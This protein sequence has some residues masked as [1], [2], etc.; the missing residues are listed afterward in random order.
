[1]MTPATIT[2]IGAVTPSRSVES[3][4][5]VV[6]NP[7]PIL[8]DPLTHTLPAKKCTKRMCARKGGVENH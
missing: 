7:P 8:S 6:P 1:M 4:K 5:S 2:T 3:V